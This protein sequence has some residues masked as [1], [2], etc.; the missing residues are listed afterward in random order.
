MVA[1]SPV[2]F[3]PICK[4]KEHFKDG[5]RELKDRSRTQRWLC[6]KCGYRFSE[7]SPL[8]TTHQ[9]RLNRS[10][11]LKLSNQICALEAKNLEP[12]TEIKNVAGVTP[13]DSSGKIIEFVWWMK[14]QG[15]KEGTVVCRSKLLK[16]M[17]KRGASLYDPETIKEV[18]AKQTWSEGRKE[19]AVNAYSTFLRMIGGTWNPP[20]Y[21]RIQK[22]PFIPKEEEI[23]A[24]I[25]SCAP[26]AATLL[27]TLK[28]TAAR[29]GEAWALQWT[30]L[31][32]ENRT[33][34]ITPEKGSNPR[35][36]KISPK[37]I[38][39][40][41]AMPRNGNCI[42][43]SYPLRGYRTCFT[44]QRKKAARKLGN[45]R[46]LQITFHTFRHW[47]A[48]M[49]YHKTKDILYVM[50]LLGHKSIKNTLIYTQLI[51]FDDNDQFVCKVAKTI[52]EASTLIESGFEYVCSMDDIKLFKKR[53]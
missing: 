7:I 17:V 11:T 47:K 46:L 30:D 42:F 3:C 2:I 51:E 16:V 45:P 10:V 52:S 48:T 25:A 49:E 35:V 15:Y 40:L 44:R 26:K 21:G 24:L 8:Q 22:L 32:I 37:L 18:I 43:G 41:L 19:N 29:V 53:N 28:E 6:K 23:D 14:K 50:K 20:I 27:Q 36:F 1:A 4:S 12:Q 34:R 9:R 39:M 13:Q 31:D 33:L 5:F 38:A